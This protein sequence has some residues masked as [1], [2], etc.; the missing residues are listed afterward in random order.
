MSDPRVTVGLPVYNGESYIG[1]AI[2]SILDQDYENFELLLAD[3]GSTDATAVI[4]E[5]AAARDGRVSVHRSEANRGAAWNYNRLVDLARGEYF[6][7]AAHDDLLEPSFLSACV[8][9]LDDD[10]QVSL[11][12]TRAVDIDE[13]GDV[14]HVH[15]LPGYATEITPSKRVAS[16]IL[17]PSPCMESFGLVRRSQLLQ[18]SRI[19]PYTSSDRTLFLELALLGRFYEVPEVLFLHRQHAQRSVHQYRDSRARNLWFDPNWHGKRSAPQWRLLR[20]YVR[21]TARSPV[22]PTERVRTFAAIGRWCGRNR[23]TL[24]REAASRLFR[25]TT[26]GAPSAQSVPTRSAS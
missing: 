10:P 5:E 22:S 26:V 11:A 7:W 1:A 21:A 14:V 6:K 8:T 9:V 20:E 12:Y 24:A 16:V 2:Q 3:N 25:R 15:D 4:C 19:G 13:R 23:R 18:T 17:D